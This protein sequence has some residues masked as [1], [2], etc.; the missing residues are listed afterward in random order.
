[1]W[2]KEGKKVKKPTKHYNIPLKEKAPPTLSSESAPGPLS[3]VSAIS[4]TWVLANAMRR[5]LDYDWRNLNYRTM[6]LPVSS[7]PHL[8]PSFHQLLST[9]VL[10]EELAVR[11]WAGVARILCVI[12]HG[13]QQWLGSP[14]TRREHQAGG[15]ILLTLCLL[16]WIACSW[17]G[18]RTLYGWSPHQIGGSPI[19]TM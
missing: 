11:N 10:W 18:S 8:L 12:H 14:P 3:L 17:P 19:L 1:M 4:I 7:P 5:C 6:Y 13:L 15:E 9:K 16:L 2:R